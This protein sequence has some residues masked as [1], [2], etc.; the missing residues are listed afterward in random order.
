MGARDLEREEGRWLMSSVKLVATIVTMT[1][2]RVVKRASE[3]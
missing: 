2:R 3:I 1:L